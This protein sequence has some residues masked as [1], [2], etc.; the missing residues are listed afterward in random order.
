MTY[1]EKVVLITIQAV[2]SAESICLFVY[3]IIYLERFSVCKVRRD[4]ASVATLSFFYL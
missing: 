4:E 1:S 2:L 3:Y